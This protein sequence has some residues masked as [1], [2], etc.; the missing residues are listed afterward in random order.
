MAIHF[1]RVDCN[2]LISLFLSPLICPSYSIILILE[3]SEWPFWT[4]AKA[5]PSWGY[6]YLG[7]PEH[8]YMV[9]SQFSCKSHVASCLSGEGF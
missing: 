8:I 9:F 3:A 5:Q 4:L 2:L 6:V 1:H 7:L